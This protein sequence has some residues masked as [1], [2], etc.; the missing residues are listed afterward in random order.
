MNRE[1]IERINELARKQKTVGLNKLEQAE[2]Q[3]LRNQYLRDFRENMRATLESV[4]VEQ[5]DGSYAPLVKRN[6]GDRGCG[7]E[8]RDR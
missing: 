8:P 2:Q 6:D 5:E 1:D 4:R 7:A 3:G